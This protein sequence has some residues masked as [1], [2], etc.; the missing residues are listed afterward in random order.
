MELCRCWNFRVR[1]KLVEEKRKPAWWIK[2]RRNWRAGALGSQKSASSIPTP[3]LG[4]TETKHG[5]WG[6]QAICRLTSDRRAQ[7]TQRLELQRR[8][9]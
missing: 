4:D 9:C 3:A 6:H 7:V 2:Q 8:S 1:R 5:A